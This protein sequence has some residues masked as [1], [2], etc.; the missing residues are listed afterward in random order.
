MSKTD[1]LIKSIIESIKT[2][3]YQ[4][5]QLI[6]SIRAMSKQRGISTY[7]VSQ[8]YE[9]LVASGHLTSI[10]GVGFLV[11][12]VSHSYPLDSNTTCLDA[13]D[14]P[15]S[16]LNQ[17]VLDTSWMMGHLFHDLPSNR[18][19]GGGLLKDD[20]L[21]DSQ[22]VGK[23]SRQAIR[24]VNQFIFSYGHLQGYLS[25]R[26]QFADKLSG[27]NIN[28]SPNQIVTTSGVSHAIELLL[29]TLCMAGDTILVDDPGWYWIIGCAQQMG[30]NVIGIPRQ[31][32]GID[33][34][35]F[36][37]CLITYH[38]KLYITN[39]RLHNPTGFGFSANNMHK[40]LSL[41]KQY[42]KNVNEADDQL[43]VDTTTLRNHAP[44]YLVE[45]DVF[46]HL[47]DSQDSKH[48]INFAVLDGFEQVIYVYGVSKS[49][50]G[51][52][53]VG[54]M[55]CPENLREDILRQKMFSVTAC[56]E[57][58]ERIVSNIL[59]DSS[60]PRHIRKMQGLIR[61]AH[62]QLVVWLNEL[63]FDIDDQ[64]YIE[65]KIS[66]LSFFIWVDVGIDS[67]TLAEDAYA[68]GWHVAPGLLFSPSGN[69]ETY[70][71]LNVGTTSR[72]FLLWLR[73]YL[74]K[75]GI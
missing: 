31:P 48:L 10:Q 16:I 52:W 23:C 29:K 28:A 68:Q 21:P 25:L 65:N 64:F 70:I 49:L 47:C 55:V 5:N 73:E 60:Y 17:Q 32:D 14:N 13:I 38:P 42:A 57:L 36:E 15:R 71:R 33:L 44:C 20:W 69:F 50:G 72:E 7:T 1:A 35:V 18:S 30:I 40:V 61:Q 67:K 66:E 22:V 37:H 75:A 6:P 45:D 62:R 24:Q 34:E 58:N 41:L 2:G 4:P 43:Q 19:P 11:K 27:Q 74:D 63:N 53:R 39:S 3:H 46:G 9:R 8:A 51:N 59:S 12:S 56:S 26:Q 54:I